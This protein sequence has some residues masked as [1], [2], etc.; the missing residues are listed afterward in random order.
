MIKT[1]KIPANI[2]LQDLCI[3]IYGTLD[4]MYNLIQLN[5]TIASFNDTTINLLA[6]T[7]INYDDTLVQKKVVQIN[8]S[9][10]APPTNVGKILGKY[11]RS[12]YDLV[13]MT[14]GSLDYIYKFI[15]DNSITNLTEDFTGKIFTYDK[16]LAQMEVRNQYNRQENI[17]YSTAAM[18]ITLAGDFNNDFNYDF[19]S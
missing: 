2:T 6:G 8:D 17:I 14:Y 3:A 11:G 10:V 15:N 13:L 5:P 4:P 18:D 12:I 7:D 1:F 19:N 9:Y 16:L